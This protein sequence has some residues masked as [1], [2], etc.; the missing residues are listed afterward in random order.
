MFEHGEVLIAYCCRCGILFPSDPDTVPS[1]YIR[2]DT[3]QPCIPGEHAAATKEPL[4]PACAQAYARAHAH[5][6]YIPWPRKNRS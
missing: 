1:L 4:C 2:P 3:G 5:G 6:G